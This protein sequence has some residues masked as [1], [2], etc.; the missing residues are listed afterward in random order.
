M[1]NPRCLMIFLLLLG[2]DRF[3]APAT[4]TIN[5][6]RAI[7]H[8]HRERSCAAFQKVDLWA[9]Q[10]E[11]RDDSEKCHLKAH[12]NIS[13]TRNTFERFCKG[14]FNLLKFIEYYLNI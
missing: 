6:E 12:K 3:A 2:A 9:G 10:V 7:V 4:P 13:I 8:R 1:L 5:C 14:E 11:I